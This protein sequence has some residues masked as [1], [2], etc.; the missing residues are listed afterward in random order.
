MKLLIALAI[1]AVG[2]LQYSDGLN[3]E[4]SGTA[5]VSVRVLKNLDDVASSR[6]SPFS[7]LELKWN[8]SFKN[9]SLDKQRY[10]LTEQVHRMGGGI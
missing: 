6:G 10:K 4:V 1:F 8:S 7:C 3:S 2:K 9:G 5:N